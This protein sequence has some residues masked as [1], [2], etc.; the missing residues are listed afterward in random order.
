MR[1]IELE[2]FPVPLYREKPKRCPSCFVLPRLAWLSIVE[3][4]TGEI[5]KVETCST[6]YCRSRAQEFAA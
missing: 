6:H 4:P 3:L 2:R 5:A 1:D